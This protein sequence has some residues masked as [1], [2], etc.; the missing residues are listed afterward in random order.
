MIKVNIYF[1]QIKPT[2]IAFPATFYSRFF[3]K[4]NN[5]KKNPLLYLIK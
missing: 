3:E 5:K 2:L 4:K 1:F